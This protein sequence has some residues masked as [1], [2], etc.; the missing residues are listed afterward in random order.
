MCGQLADTADH[1]DGTDY[2]TQRYDLAMLR[3]LCT[4][5]HRRRTALQGVEARRRKKGTAT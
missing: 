5:C 4:P 1:I 3:S 2:T